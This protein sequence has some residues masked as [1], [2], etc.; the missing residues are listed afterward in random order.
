ML[1]MGALAI[2]V[3]HCVLTTGLGAT[4]D[5]REYMLAAGRLLRYRALLSPLI[6]NDA[7]ATVSGLLPPGYVAVVAGVYAVLGIH[8]E[9][10]TVGLQLINAAATSL[11]A[12]GCFFIARRLSGDLG[13]WLA[14]AIAAVNP[15]LFGYTSYVWDTSLF[16]LTVVAT[17]WLG[18]RLGERARG[19]GAWVGFGLWLGAVA[20]LNPSLTS[21]YPFLVLWPLICVHGWRPRAVG[22]G[23][24][25]AIA[26]WVIAVAPWTVRNLHQLGEPT[27]IRT[28][29]PLELWLGVCPEADPGG[30]TVYAGQFPLMNPDVQRH[31]AAVGE[32]A[33]IEEAA[34]KS[35]KAIRRDPWRFA[36]LMMIRAADYWAGTVFSHSADGGGWPSGTGRSLVTVFLSLETLTVVAL[37][38]V[39]RRVG[40]D[41]GWLLGT[42]FIF[43]LVYCIT[44]VQVR[45]R[46]PTEPILA[47]VL[48]VWLH[49]HF[50]RKGATMTDRGL[51]AVLPPGSLRGAQPARHAGSGQL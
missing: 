28:G 22:K 35:Q 7:E 25:L 15:T 24:V 6:L 8:T 11:A 12:V 10:S 32:A 23:V 44:H 4:P 51:D 36:R 18:V 9:V 31:L 17:L 34:R 40:P 5:Y 47:V 1:F 16:V 3:G 42:V 19:G 29:F 2:R 14:A 38:A 33:F 46:A 27:Y 30:P 49:E 20:L 48:G 39:R 13:G 41:I 21:A 43:S 26:G 37:L 50:Q 45:F